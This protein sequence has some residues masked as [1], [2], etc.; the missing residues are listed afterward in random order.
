ME[1][2]KNEQSHRE[3]GGM[4]GGGGVLQKDTTTNINR[5][6]IIPFHCVTMLQTLSI[7]LC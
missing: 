3:H 2:N 1:R 7:S 6:A 4:V 5:N